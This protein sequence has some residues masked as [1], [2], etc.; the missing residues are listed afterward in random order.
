MMAVK[1]SLEFELTPMP[2]ALCT[3]NQFIR[4]TEKAVLG[5]YLKKKAAPQSASDPNINPQL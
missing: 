1:E 4:I 2:M 3:E 5:N